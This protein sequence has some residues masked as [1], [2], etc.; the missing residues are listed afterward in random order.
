MCKGKDAKSIFEA[1]EHYP[2]RENVKVVVIDL[3]NGYLSIVR[4]LFPS[5]KIV[6]DKFHALRLLSPAMMKLRK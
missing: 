1:V 3:S 4:K 6:A 2:G 5:A